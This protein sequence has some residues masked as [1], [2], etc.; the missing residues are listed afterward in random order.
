MTDKTL[1]E[2]ISAEDLL[3]DFERAIIDEIREGG[4]FNTEVVDASRRAILN[5]IS[6]VTRERD[7]LRDAVNWALGVGDSNFR[8]PLDGE[9]R[10]Y[11]RAELSNRAFGEAK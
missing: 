3:A 11:W 1:K 5:R 8:P 9:G 7:Q 4:F 6:D 10:Y 2:S